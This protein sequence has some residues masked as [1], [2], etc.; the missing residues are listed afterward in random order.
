MNVLITRTSNIFLPFLMSFKIFGVLTSL[1]RIVFGDV[2]C[3]NVAFKYGTERV[4]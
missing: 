4:K 2:T 1:Y 3:M